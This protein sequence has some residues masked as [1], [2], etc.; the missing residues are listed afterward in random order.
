MP[1]SLVEINYSEWCAQHELLY[2]PIHRIIEDDKPSVLLCPSI[3]PH[4][5]GLLEYKFHEAAKTISCNGLLIIWEASEIPERD[6]FYSMCAY[7]L[8]N[9]F[10]ELWR[11]VVDA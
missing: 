11:D 7:M 10:P 5:L 3:I 4:L 8:K 9:V 1:R 2:G 6:R